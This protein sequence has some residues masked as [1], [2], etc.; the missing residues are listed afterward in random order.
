MTSPHHHHLEMFVKRLHVRLFRTPQQKKS[1]NTA[2]LIVNNVDR[3]N[4]LRS[5]DLCGFCANKS[6]YTTDNLTAAEELGLRIRTS[7]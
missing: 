2:S 7:L 1:G 4:V 3:N 6:S 5:D